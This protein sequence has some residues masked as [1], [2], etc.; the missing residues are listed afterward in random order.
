MTFMILGKLK[1]R[2][3]LKWN[4]TRI[5]NELKKCETQ[6][7]RYQRILITYRLFETAESFVQYNEALRRYTGD[8]QRFI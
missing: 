5:S 7:Y 2:N 6:Q 8:L 3:T 4:G 1:F